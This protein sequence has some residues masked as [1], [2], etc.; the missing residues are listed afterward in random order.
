MAQTLNC[1]KKTSSRDL[2]TCGNGKGEAFFEKK[3]YLK[4][5]ENLF[6]RSDESRNS[7]Q[8]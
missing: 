4:Y 3:K 1:I 8:M 6:C 7:V 5:L 2:L